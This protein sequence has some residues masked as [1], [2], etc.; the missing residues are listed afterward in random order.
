[1]SMTVRIVTS[2]IA[3][4]ALAACVEPPAPVG[5]GT[6]TT[7][8]TLGVDYLLSC[9]ATGG[10]GCRTVLGLPRMRTE[11]VRWD[12][13]YGG[14]Y[15]WTAQTMLQ[16]SYDRVCVGGTA[17]AYSGGGC[18]A[19]T[20]LTGNG[21]FN[22]TGSGATTVSL[23]T[24]YSGSSQGLVSLTATC[25]DAIHTGVFRQG[26][27][28]QHFLTGRTWTQL[29]ADLASEQTDGYRLARIERYY[30]EPGTPRFD[31]LFEEAG[32]GWAVVP[33]LTYAQ[34]D[35]KR[36]ELTTLDLVD[37]EA[38]HNGSGIRYLGVW[39][40]GSRNQDLYNGG[41]AGFTTW[42]GTAFAA[43][44][45]MIDLEVYFSATGVK[46][47]TATANRVGAPGMKIE[48]NKRW[49][50]LMELWE[51][52]S[53]TGWRLIDLE[54]YTIGGVRYYDGVFVPGSG[55]HDVIGGARP[56][57]FG[58][59]R[60]GHAANGRRLVDIDRLEG[61]W[62]SSDWG[63]QDRQQE[64]ALPELDPDWMLEL[65]HHFE[66]TL[67]GSPMGYSY[68]AMR[69][70]RLLAAGSY[71]YARAPGEGNKLMTTQ[72]Q[73]DLLSISKMWTFIA[74]VKLMEQ[75][76][77]DAEDEIGPYLEGVITMPSSSDT[78]TFRNLINHRSGFQEISCDGGTGTWE[79]LVA[80]RHT[81]TIGEHIYS[82]ANSCLARVL[83]QELSGKDYVTYIDT[84]ILRPMGLHG[85]D[86]TKDT[87][88]VEVLEYGVTP[89]HGTGYSEPNMWCAS[90]G[91]KLRPLDMLVY[92]Q[93]LRTPGL[94]LNA[95]A[96]AMVEDIQPGWGRN[97]VSGN[98]VWASQGARYG[99]TTAA[100]SLPNGVDAVFFGNSTGADMWRQ[101]GEAYAIDPVP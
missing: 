75:H 50:E 33:D 49:P 8:S 101:L 80:V 19:G 24:G 29:D 97:I 77:I 51:Q 15:R 17:S 70:G 39:R 25:T 52:H 61:E 63:E 37:V 81:G 3:C 84:A 92:L 55:A 60:M 47:Y 31:A 35:A 1:M 62:S 99:A 13:C 34:L 69:N 46:Q 71:G 23:A 58:A 41:E 11:A 22:G 12:P 88:K 44:Y 21:T 4:G 82:G 98:E 90:A 95:A 93:G 42:L 65:Q 86:C 43:G 36:A 53:D 76:G 59:A 64:N 85:I 72:S 54:A 67:G 74:L 56:Q 66:A 32:G 7:A 6:T 79:H 5:T 87:D 10:R 28:A 89:N 48:V 27:G 20:E 2:L 9:D 16:A 68:A 96:L 18:S 40:E 83:V 26:T 91:W 30:D 94:A 100:V 14:G 78:V 73:W 45:Q 38:Y 57:E